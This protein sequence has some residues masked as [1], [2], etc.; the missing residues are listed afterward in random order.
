M[1]DRTDVDVIFMGS[2]ELKGVPGLTEI[3]HLVPR[4][5]A[6]R[7]AVYQQEQQQTSPPAVVCDEKTANQ[8][9][10]EDDDDETPS[11][12]SDASATRV[13]FSRTGTVSVCIE[14]EA[15]LFATLLRLALKACRPE[16][17]TVIVKSL[18]QRWRVAIPEDFRM[19][20]GAMDLSRIK[21]PTLPKKADLI[22]FER[23]IATATP[24]QYQQ[25]LLES[26]LLQI[27][28]RC[29]GGIHR[30]S[31]QSRGG[32]GVLLDLL[33]RS[34]INSLPKELSFRTPGTQ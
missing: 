1:N 31:P 30:R 17:V 2:V 5:L 18:A 23:T 9:D 14:E 13:S 21:S 32:E 27:G 26:I 16:E 20:R 28:Q 29:T 7:S 22:E 3:L 4:G 6:G 34:G 15:K 19:V 25:Q 33:E 12:A 8:C 10:D 24:Q 11:V